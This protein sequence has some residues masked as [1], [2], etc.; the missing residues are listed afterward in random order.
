M[1]LLLVRHGEAL[2]N[3]EGV[4]VLSATGRQEAQ[5]A[6][7]WLRDTGI[8]ILYWSPIRRTRETMLALGQQP[9]AAGGPDD[10]LCEIRP[11]PGPPPRERGTH[12]TVHGYETWT[13]FLARTADC[14]TDL[15]DQHAHQSVGLL[16]HRGIFD[17]VH[18]LAT[19]SA[20]RV[21]LAVGHGCITSWT[22]NRRA[23]SGKWILNFHNLRPP[24]SKFPPGE[25]EYHAGIDPAVSHHLP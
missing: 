20:R 4:R 18:E 8:D 19:G 5:A 25:N 11:G 24:R 16:T 22:Y 17:A 2:L 9:W 10:R 23:R 3:H 12:E 1:N 6:G 7:R 13:D 21:E 14:L 15:L